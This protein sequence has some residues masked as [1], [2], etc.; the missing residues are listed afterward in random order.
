MNRL[1]RIHNVCIIRT[2]KVASIIFYENHYRHDACRLFVGDR[3][4]VKLLFSDLA[5]SSAGKVE[6]IFV[7]EFG[8]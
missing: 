4:N 1:T 7:C 3:E 6:F 2:G 5:V 8:K